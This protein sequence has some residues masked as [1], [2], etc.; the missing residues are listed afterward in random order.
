MLEIKELYAS[1]NE[2]ALLKGIS[3]TINKGQIHAI[4]GP[5]GAGKSTLARILAGDPAY[6]VT[7]GELLFEGQNIL[8]LSPEERAHLGLF[9]GFQY[10][11]ELPGILNSQFLEGSF[12]RR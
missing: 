8:D 2:T 5:N 1:V 11:V 12:S 3:L 4:M 10:P 9:L 6:E 7:S